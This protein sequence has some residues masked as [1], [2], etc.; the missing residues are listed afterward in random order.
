M[1]LATRFNRSANIG[2]LAGFW[3]QHLEH[4]VAALGGAMPVKTGAEGAVSLIAPAALLATFVQMELP[5]AIDRPLRILVLSDDPIGLMDQGVWCH[6]AA[7]FA[8]VAGGVELYS[9]SD[10]TFQSNLHPV[11]TALG[12]KPFSRLTFEEA[13]EQSWDLVSWLHPAIESPNGAETALLVSALQRAGSPVYACMYNELDMMVQTYGMNEH[14]FDFRCVGTEGRALSASAVNRFGIS[15]LSTGVDGGWGAVM[16]KLHPSVETFAA[17]DWKVIQ[18]AMNVLRLDGVREA[19]WSFGQTVS[20]VAF[21]R[22]LPVGLIG[23]LAI[24][25]ASGQVF[26]HSPI[27]N[28][29]NVIGH[30]WLPLR[31]EKP[32]DRFRLLPW[33]CRIKLCFTQRLTK[34]TKARADTIDLLSSA[35]CAGL[36]EAGIALARSYESVGTKDALNKAFAI[37]EELG[38]GHPLSAYALAHT[39]YAAGRTAEAI[40]MFE[41]AAKAGYIPAMTD[42]A[43]LHLD[44]GRRHLGLQLLGEAASHGDAEANFVFAEELITAGAHFEAVKR[45]RLAWSV[46]HDD[47]LR[48]AGWLCDML[49]RS[50]A[51]KSGEIKREL[52]DIRFYANKRERRAAAL[53]SAVA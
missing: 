52:K 7:D 30:V 6:Y 35:Y 15:I 19:P 37:Y 36:P 32:A 13:R 21:G 26:C 48:V 11:A 49:L 27:T 10:Q 31:D 25:S 51:G 12:L 28:V 9:V 24:D 8:G 45:L 5:T 1:N 16:A 2:E 46:G 14:G 40:E 33:A 42:L 4:E 23:D 41:A 29:L 18:V 34:E 38:T 43:R 39:R 20:G 53:R 17:P 50:K 3:L 44:A 47:A 22:F